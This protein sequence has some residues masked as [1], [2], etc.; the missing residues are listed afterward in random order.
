[1]TVTHHVADNVHGVKSATEIS[2]HCRRQM[3]GNCQTV[4]H[5]FEF[6]ALLTASDHHHRPTLEIY[7]NHWSEEGSHEA[8]ILAGQKDR[9]SEVQVAARCGRGTPWLAGSHSV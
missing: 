6:L 9:W 4:T 8:V 3:K 2:E 5:F 1:M 7:F